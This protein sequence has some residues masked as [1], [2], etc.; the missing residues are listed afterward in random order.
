MK[1]V[2]TGSLLALLLWSSG[3]CNCQGVETKR[4]VPKP[5]VPLIVGGV[6]YTAP[7]DMMGYIVADDRSGNQLWS[8][9]IYTVIYDSLLETDVQDTYIDSIYWDSGKL[10]IRD[11]RKG[12]YAMDGDTREVIKIHGPVRPTPAPVSPLVV[13]QVKYTAPADS[14][15]YIVAFD[16]AGN[17]LW[18]KRIYAVS[19]VDTIEAAWQ[20]C[21]ICSIYLNRHKFY[22][23]NEC[24]NLYTLDLKTREVTKI[25]EF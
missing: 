17:W 12:L 20:D 5:V 11:E 14:M 6:R 10:Y 9:K 13:G 15:G 7:T 3:E 21:Y 22:I 25:H 19:Y 1:I 16:L 18:S 23:R 8:Q 2:F 4:G 24:G